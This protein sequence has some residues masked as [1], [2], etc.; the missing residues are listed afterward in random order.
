M[1]I[2]KTVKRVPLTNHGSPYAKVMLCVT[3]Q[4]E[5]GSPDVLQSH[6][7]KRLKNWGLYADFWKERKI[8]NELVV[9]QVLKEKH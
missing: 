8:F 4:M 6:F 2:Y 1:L 3:N 5:T 7:F 9:F